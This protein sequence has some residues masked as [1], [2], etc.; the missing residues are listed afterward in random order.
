MSAR[1][2]PGAIP[3]V[4]TARGIVVLAADT[5]PTL[6]SR[7]W[8]QVGAGRGLAAVLEA[9][10]GAYG[11]SLSAIPPFA[12]VLAEGD[13]VR[14]AV[15]GDISVDIEMS[16]AS[17]RVSGTGVTTWSERVLTDVTRVL[18]EAAKPTAPADLPISDGVV[19]AAVIEWSPRDR[20]IT[21]PVERPSAERDLRPGAEPEATNE[22]SE[23]T[24]AAEPD[25]GDLTERADA[26]PARAAPAPAAASVPAAPAPED[27]VVL[28][29]ADPPSQPIAAMPV[30]PSVSRTASELAPAPPS[31][32]LID[33]AA[34]LSLADADTLLPAE[35]TFTVRH[36][37]EAPDV[38]LAASLAPAPV[39]VD[40]ELGRTVIRGDG[41][42]LPTPVL[43][44]HDGETISLA[45]AQALRAGGDPSAA[46]PPLAP[47]RPPAPGRLR[48]STGQVVPLNRTVVLGRRPRSTRITGTDLPHLIAVESPQQ[49]ISRSHVELRVEGD[50][51]IATDLNTTNGT[52]LLRS[53]SDP[54]RLHPGE[55][56]V[57]VPGDILDLGDGITVAIEDVA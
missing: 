31:P 49:D 23:S 32:A 14:L 43:G 8:A 41:S 19:L 16:T 25:L 7:I 22:E 40:D 4:V 47:P 20:P 18:V 48:L 30:P 3:V 24:G 51:I 1:Y 28:D 21:E 9:L 54:V 6:V 50:S 11:T 27:E 39:G 44:D 52:L 55:P 34:V 42:S 46:A 29:E 10:T 57:V 45:Q 53:G 36:D 56:T 5:S 15:R 33:S 12:V 35:S 37:D 13:A 38:E 26:A 2:S 17:E